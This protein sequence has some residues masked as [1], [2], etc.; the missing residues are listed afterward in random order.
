MKKLI[1]TICF[2]LIASTAWSAELLIQAKP[3]WMD[4]KT[5]LEI[6]YLSPLMKQDYEARGRVG[7]I[8]LARQDGWKWG[9]EEKLPRFIV[10]KIPSISIEEAQGYL[11]SLGKEE[12]LKRINKF[13]IDTTKIEQAISDKTDVITLEKKDIK[14]KTGDISE[15]KSPKTDFI[16]YYKYFKRTLGNAFDK[17]D[18]RKAHAATLLYK[19]VCPSGC[20]YTA[21]GSALSG[22]QQNLVSNDKY[23]EIEIKETW[24]SPDSVATYDSYTT[25][26]TRYVYIYTSGDARHEGIFSTSKYYVSFTTGRCMTQ[27]RGNMAIDGIQC[28]KTSVGYDDDS[29][30]TN[31]GYMTNGDFLGF[32]NII[33]NSTDTATTYFAHGLR[34][35]NANL[36]YYVFNCIFDSIIGADNNAYEGT[37]NG[38]IQ[39]VY[40][41]TFI[42]NTQV[43]TPGN[44]STAKN[45]GQSGSVGASSAGT[46]V[47]CSSSTPT[48]VGGIDYHLQSGDSTWQ[49]QGTDLSGESFP[50]IGS[51]TTDIDGDTRSGSWDI[52]ADEYVSAGG[53][54]T[55]WVT[56]ITN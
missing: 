36:N 26:A 4:E 17:I 14:E 41:S 32:Y 34:N 20:D 27:Y 21:L 35:V 47:T 55:G 44:G 25:D 16:S 10:A 19:D 30:F 28:N 48:F 8:I 13:Y 40:N 49:D 37:I 11:G 9:K 12:T 3:H 1:L 53:A 54:Y 52:G 42:G 31:S 6:S 56:I 50:V 5:Q 18:I 2:C 43:Y 46:E 29:Y 7:D 51:L 45:I 23:F 24:S 33:F 22:N 15:V 39:K 38:I